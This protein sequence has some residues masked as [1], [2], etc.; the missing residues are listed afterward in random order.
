VIERE[1]ERERER[2]EEVLATVR[3]KKSTTGSEG[4]RRFE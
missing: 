4:V 2:R 1:R 3:E